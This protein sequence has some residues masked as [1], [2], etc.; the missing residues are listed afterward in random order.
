MLRIPCS[1]K[2]PA[3]GRVL[4]N[5]QDATG[6]SVQERRAG[7]ILKSYALF[8]HTTVLAIIAHG[9]D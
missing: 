4:F 2:F 3:S 9:R 8:R 6:L 7:F 5:I 1:P